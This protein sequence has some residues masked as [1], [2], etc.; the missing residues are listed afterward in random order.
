[1]TSLLFAVKKK[2]KKR[3]LT[4]GWAERTLLAC[5]RPGDLILRITKERKKSIKAYLN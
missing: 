2:K 3:K 4:Q 1:V 5:P